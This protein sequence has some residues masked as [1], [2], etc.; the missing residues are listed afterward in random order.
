[1]RRINGR[2][3]GVVLAAL[4]VLPA[5]CTAVVPGTSPS[6]SVSPSVDLV[7]A[8]R[9]AGIEDCP[10]PTG[11]PVP[12]G[13]PDLTLDCLGGDATVPLGALRGPLLI[14][15]WAQ[16]CLPC[17]QEAPVLAAFDAARDDVGVLGINYDD[18]E[19]DWAIEF[20]RISGWTWPQLADPDKTIRASL[21]IPG[22]PVTL[23]LDADGRIVR[24]HFGAFEDLDQLSGWVDEGL[25]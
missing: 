8:R 18:P 3:A 4:T 9:A 5:G 7:A 2:V 24:R 23:L 13:L 19:P 17:R 20:A 22:L 15:L 25:A 16:W 6:P 12:D 21:G 10:Q 14:N 1:M 11:E